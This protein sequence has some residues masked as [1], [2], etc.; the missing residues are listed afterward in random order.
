MGRPEDEKSRGAQPD[1][2]R[3]ETTP[4]GSAMQEPISRRGFLKRYG[5]PVAGMTA[6]G[7]LV[8]GAG[9]N[10]ARLLSNSRE[11]VTPPA[12]EVHVAAEFL[13]D[14]QKGEIQALKEKKIRELEE[15]E[16]MSLRSSGDFPGVPGMRLTILSHKDRI[17]ETNVNGVAAGLEALF[18]AAEQEESGPHRNHLL[19]ARE[20]VRQGRFAGTGAEIVLAYSGASSTFPS[21]RDTDPEEFSAFVLIPEGATFADL[22][23]REPTQGLLESELAVVY[24]MNAG[25]IGG[26]SQRILDG[27]AYDL[28]P[29]RALQAMTAHELGHAMLRFMGVSRDHAE[30]SFMKDRIEPRVIEFFKKNPAPLPLRYL[31]EK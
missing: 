22:S 16:G 30:E 12:H 24:S 20:A 23:D 18:A 31:Q 4:S 21:P 13:S 17:V 1:Q 3:D 26:V 15:K 2:V 19:S 7:V 9:W 8:G 11:G 27:R 10:V 14:A 5:V 25:A 28:S 29:E 6:G